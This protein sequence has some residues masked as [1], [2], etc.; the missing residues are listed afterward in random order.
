MVR[1]LA[2]VVD[3]LSDESRKKELQS[4]RNLRW[5]RSDQIDG[6]HRSSVKEGNRM[7]VLVVRATRTEKNL[8]EQLIQFYIYDFTE[9][10]G[11]AI[12]E[13]G[14]YRSMPDIDK[15]WNEPLRHHPYLIKVNSEAAG[16]ILIKERDEQSKC[17][18]FAHLFVLR[19]FRRTGVGRVAAEY[20]L[21]QYGGEWELHQ[22]DNNA[23]AQRFW[24][25]IINEI[26]D[27]N[28]TVRLENGRRYQHF[29][30]K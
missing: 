13:D 27:G 30:C 2:L 1:T 10:T 16:F 12:R 29:T 7:N 23:P 19:K 14:T 4:N 21:Q 5:A 24:D 17:N 8:M 15:Y 11:V 22:L 6:G 18:V 26:S 3:E 9:Y 25:R 28:V 20:L